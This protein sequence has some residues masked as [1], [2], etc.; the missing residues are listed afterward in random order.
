MQASQPISQPNLTL[1]GNL[2]IE[3]FTKKNLSRPEDKYIKLLPHSVRAA[4][5]APGGRD[6]GEAGTG[7]V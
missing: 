1:T 6:L 4:I 2:K 5:F 3:P 7:G